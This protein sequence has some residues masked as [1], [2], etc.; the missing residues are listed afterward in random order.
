M[1]VHVPAF[2]ALKGE[3]EFRGAEVKNAAFI[4][5]IY[6]EVIQIVTSEKTKIAVLMINKVNLSDRSANRIAEGRRQL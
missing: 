4:G 3:A 2:Q 1:A 6:P 5:H